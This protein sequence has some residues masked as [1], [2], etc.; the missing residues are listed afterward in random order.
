M[1]T[2]LPE[3][4]P[5]HPNT[6]QTRDYLVMRHSSLAHNNSL[7]FKKTGTLH[8]GVLRA[9]RCWR[10][11]PLICRGGWSQLILEATFFLPT[12]KTWRSFFIKEGENDG[13]TDRPTDQEMAD[14][15]CSLRVKPRTKWGSQD[16][17]ADLISCKDDMGQQAEKE[18]FYWGY[19]IS[20]VV[21]H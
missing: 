5:L 20:P 3:A 19:Y 10:R 8:R 11:G 12:N 16:T 21:I 17:A 1:E 2:R 13:L 15:V 14:T 6:Q 4:Q 7:T 18:E 9:V